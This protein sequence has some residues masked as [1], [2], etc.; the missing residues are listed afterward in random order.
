MV[1]WFPLH[2]E[3]AVVL[4]SL[5]VDDG[6]S[7]CRFLLILVVPR[8]HPL[9][10]VPDD[11]QVGHQNVGPHDGAVTCHGIDGLLGVKSQVK[12]TFEGNPQIS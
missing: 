7:L 3:V 4:Q 1:P 10:E 2:L 11:P 6:T 5:V 12:V 9:P 8:E